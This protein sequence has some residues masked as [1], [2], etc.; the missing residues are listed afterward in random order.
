[1]KPGFDARVYAGPDTFAR[2]I[3]TLAVRD[4]DQGAYLMHDGNWL[5]V[6]EGVAAGSEMGLLLPAASIEAIAT[7]IA[8]Y[9]GHTSHADTEARVLREWLAAE[10]A[11]VDQVL[12]K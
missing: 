1:M 6:P 2:N 10:R 9:Q 5:T 11:R 8:E 3:V 7:A 4:N 12:S